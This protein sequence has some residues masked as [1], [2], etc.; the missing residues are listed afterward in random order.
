M[1][2]PQ[3]EEVKTLQNVIK[4]FLEK[5]EDL[6][7]SDSKLIANVWRDE[8]NSMLGEGILKRMSAYQ[9]FAEILAQD[10]ISSADSIVRSRRKIQ[11]DNEN[12]RGNNYKLRKQHEVEFRNNINA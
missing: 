8:M 9:F 4:N 10:K 12:L 1:K 6:R 5:R 11:R 7:D 3:L 2:T